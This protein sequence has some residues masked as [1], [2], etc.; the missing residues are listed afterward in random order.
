MNEKV[1]DFLA[2][3]LDSYISGCVDG[4]ETVISEAILQVSAIDTVL[5]CLVSVEEYKEI[6]REAK[7]RAAVLAPAT[8]MSHRL[9]ATFYSNRG[10]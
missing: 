8:W 1:A 9:Q 6:W 5:M 7:R 10:V 3:V 2:E 4:S